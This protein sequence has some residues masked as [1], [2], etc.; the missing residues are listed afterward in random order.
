VEETWNAME[1]E[2]G[3]EKGVMENT[4]T[5]HARPDDDCTTSEKRLNFDFGDL[6]RTVS[7][8]GSVHWLDA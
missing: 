4:D 3:Q 7:Q 2:E 8:L 6:T 1:G 5:S